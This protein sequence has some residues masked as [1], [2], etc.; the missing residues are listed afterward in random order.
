VAERPIDDPTD[1]RLNGANY[2]PSALASHLPLDLVVLM[3]GTNDTKSYFHRSP[4]E[5][6]AAVSTLIGQIAYSAGGVGTV[7]PAPKMLLIAPPPLAAMP[8]PWFSELFK[9]GRE[10]TIDLAKQYRNLARFLQIAFLDAGEIMS[11]DGVDG[12]HFSE[13]TTWPSAKQW[14]ALSAPR[15][16]L[17]DSKRRRRAIFRKRSFDI[18]LADIELSP[19]SG[20]RCSTREYR[21]LLN[22]T[23]KRS[24]VALGHPV[25]FCRFPHLLCAAERAQNSTGFRP[26]FLFIENFSS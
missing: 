3:L 9:G 21:T 16:C 4:F 12:I 25:R 11:T 22:Q 19:Q 26:Q 20:V 15:S 6:A 17:N 10:K 18:A 5:I 2:L 1:P 8:T 13:V 24:A 23:K 14:P 7:Y